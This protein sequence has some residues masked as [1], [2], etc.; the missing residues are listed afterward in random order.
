MTLD[1]GIQHLEEKLQQD[2]FQCEECRKE[3]VELLEWLKELR[4]SRKVIRVIQ[5]QLLNSNVSP[6]CD[7][8]MGTNC[9]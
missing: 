1:Q 2:S 6:L 3:H 4:E 7:G 9:D 5:E 8:R